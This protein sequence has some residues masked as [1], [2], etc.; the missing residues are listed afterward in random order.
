MVN[1]E[2]LLYVIG[3]LLKVLISFSLLKLLS[4]LATA[5]GSLAISEV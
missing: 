2:S 4:A 3:D 1:E 5:T